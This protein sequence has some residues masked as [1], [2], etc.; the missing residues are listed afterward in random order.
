MT[1]QFVERFRWWV[2][3]LKILICIYSSEDELI[4]DADDVN[5][6]KSNPEMDAKLSKLKA[7]LQS[8]KN[9]SDHEEEEENR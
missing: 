3:R 7:Q 8:I 6:A 4:D 9:L 1:S 5:V 2:G